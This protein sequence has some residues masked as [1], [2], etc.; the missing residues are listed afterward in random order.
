MASAK[1]VVQDAEASAGGDAMNRK[2][3]MVKFDS[4]PTGLP[5]RLPHSEV[6]AATDEARSESQDRRLELLREWIAAVMPGEPFSLAPASSD[7]SF[8][9][10]FRVTFQ[11]GRTLIA[12]DAPPP[13]ED[14]R[15]FVDVARRLVAAGVHAPEVH[16]EDF[17]RGFLLLSDLG[18]RTYL[19][20]LDAGSARGLYRDALASL[21]RMQ[22]HARVDGLNPYD[23]AVQQRELDLFPD[24]YVAR[25]CTVQ[26]TDA[27]KAMWRQGCDVL[28][29]NTLEQPKAFVHRDYH[30]RNL[31]VCSERDG[32]PGILDFQ[33][34]L[35]GP[36]TYD[37]VS[38]LKDAYI[39]WDEEFVL[40]QVARYWDSARRAK[41]PVD[42]DFA[43]FYRDFEWMGVQRQ[44]KVLG[45]FA[46]LY[47]RDGKSAYLADMPRVADGV[48]AACLR[49]G[50]LHPFVPLLE[51]VGLVESSTETPVTYTF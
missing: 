6:T 23:R 7:A 16:A 41:L 30:S 35:D 51:S 12:M 29:A 5:S 48:V 34:A 3:G 11:S 49:Y 13:Q 27:Q 50:Q 38:L 39:K 43:A 47:H 4:K 31:M 24:W 26:W 44:L 36:V 45:I 25:H 14:C 20:A 1:Q 19:S 8:R 32:N 22:S 40:D 46:R 28:L 2:L 9:R 10:Y 17:V 33:D 37:L 21:V 18:T 15:P 42:P